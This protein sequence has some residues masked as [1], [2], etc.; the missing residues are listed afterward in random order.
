[1]IASRAREYLVGGRASGV[2]ALGA[3]LLIE[4]SSSR[5]HTPVS[6]IALRWNFLLVLFLHQL[7]ESIGGD[8]D[9]PSQSYRRKDSLTQLLV[10]QVPTQAMPFR[11]FAYR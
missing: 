3:H 7:L 5:Y 1:M 4:L 11:E 6:L 8:E 9:P 10:Y 2:Q